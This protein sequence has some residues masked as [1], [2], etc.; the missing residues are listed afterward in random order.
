MVSGPSLVELTQAHAQGQPQLCLYTFL[1]AEASEEER[2]SCALLDLRARALA[3][4]LQTER[5]VGERV[6]LLYPAGLEFIVSFLS[7]LYAGAVAVPAYP[8]RRNRG[9]DRLRAIVRD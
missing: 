5:A 7:C 1:R 4:R 3:A 2:L 9:Q 6:L 8:P